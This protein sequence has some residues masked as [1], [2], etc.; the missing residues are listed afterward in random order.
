M[1]EMKMEV[2]GTGL[3]KMNLMKILLVALSF[4]SLACEDESDTR[5]Y[6]D[7]NRELA[8]RDFEETLKEAGESLGALMGSQSSALNAGK[9]LKKE[10]KEWGQQMQGILQPAVVASRKLLETYGISES[11]ITRELGVSDD[12]RLVLVGIWIAKSERQGLQA[13]HAYQAQ[14]ADFSFFL[15]DNTLIGGSQD[16]MDCM[17][18][19][20]GVDAIIEF[21]KGNV[22]EA[23]A[24]KAI[25]KIAS[26]TLGWVGVA[27]ALYEY[28]NCMGWY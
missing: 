21:A 5:E 18:V 11:F 13:Q 12:P 20:V 28:G 26:R 2:Y 6:P 24:K 14:H 19:A 9:N 10:G 25:R 4:F 23:I 27:L 8:I 22:T 1:M 16:W 7:I 17:L 3:T 15:Q